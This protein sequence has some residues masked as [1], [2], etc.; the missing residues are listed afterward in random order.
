MHIGDL[1]VPLDQNGYAH[2]K[3]ADMTNQDYHSLFV[4][5][6]QYISFTGRASRNRRGAVPVPAS[7]QFTADTVDIE[8]D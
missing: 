1:T 3:K 2:K 4:L 8:K 7:V 6:Q 5:Q